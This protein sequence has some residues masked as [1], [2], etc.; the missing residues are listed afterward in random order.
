[1]LR[2]PQRADSARSIPWSSNPW[3]IFYAV[4]DGW[5]RSVARCAV[6]DCA[7]VPPFPERIIRFRRGDRHESRCPAQT[8]R[9][10]G[11]PGRSRPDSSQRGESSWQAPVGGKNQA[12][13]GENHMLEAFN[14]P[15]H[16]SNGVCQSIDF[17]RYHFTIPIITTTRRF[18]PTSFY[19]PI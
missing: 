6:A 14:T 19:P 2:S 7:S 5:H 4:S 11:R 16:H 12:T 8:S 1:M 10:R 18:S 15:I 17:G 13:A 3:L 9:H